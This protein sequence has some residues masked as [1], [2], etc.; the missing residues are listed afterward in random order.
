MKTRE[1]WRGHR[2][3]TC[4][5]LP[6]LWQPL[7]LHCNYRWL[8]VL[9]AL[10]SL[11]YHHLRLLYPLGPIHTYSDLVQDVIKE[12]RADLTPVFCLM[13]HASLAHL[14]A[15]LVVSRPYTRGADRLMAATACWRCLPVWN[16]RMILTTR[17][18]SSFE[19]WYCGRFMSCSSTGVSTSS[20]APGTACSSTS[21]ARLPVLLGLTAS[22][23]ALKYA[24]R[25]A[26]LSPIASLAVEIPSLTWRLCYLPCRAVKCL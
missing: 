11:L 15:I 20:R 18:L 4:P 2:P 3:H 17:A 19:K 16:R 23:Q 13:L 1:Y 21:R 22:A 26:G 7:A 14:L 9:L 12:L 24:C 5:A 6:P 8:Y 25:S 10:T